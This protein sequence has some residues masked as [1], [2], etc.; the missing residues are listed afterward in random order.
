MDHGAIDSVIAVRL[1]IRQSFQESIHHHHH[2]HHC[3]RNYYRRRHHSI[4]WR[5]FPPLRN[6]SCCR[7]PYSRRMSRR[8]CLSCLRQ[9]SP[10][11]SVCQIRCWRPGRRSGYRE[12]GVEKSLVMASTG[13]SGWVLRPEGSIGGN[14]LSIV[15]LISPCRFL[16]LR[17]NIRSQIACVQFMS[18]LGNQRTAHCSCNS[19]DS[20]GQD[21]CNTQL[22]CSPSEAKNCLRDG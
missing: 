21:K 17:N 19:S 15:F 5:L 16:I 7:H 20:Q 8:K 18:F 22:E 14:R 11:Y 3:V 6:C 12:T 9:G 1:Y 13:L 2:H 4:A 10:Y